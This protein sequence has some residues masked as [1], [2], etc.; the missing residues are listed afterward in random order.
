M[1]DNFSQQSELYKQYRPEYPKEMYDFILSLVPNKNIV[2]D[3]GT[4]NGQIAKVLCSHFNQVFATDISEQQLA[5]AIAANNIKYSKQAAEETNF[6][7]KIFDLI[8]VGQAVHWFDFSK[9]YAEVNRTLKKDGLVAIIGY[10]RMSIDNHIDKIIDHLYFD[11]LG[12][13]W[14]AERKYVDENY[15]T[16]PF[17]FIE[18]KSPEFQNKYYWTL[19]HLVGYLETWSAI[20][21]YKNK[22]KKNPIDFVID[23]LKHDWPQD[24]AKEINFPI[25]SR[26]GKLN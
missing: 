26:L 3:C 20:K 14:D 4:G 19:A 12:N 18:I 9:F 10:G 15:K 16:I 2:W 13:Y 24:F 7:N 5:N 8:I 6:A 11:I 25:I 1:K 17:P 22:E 21:H 23:D